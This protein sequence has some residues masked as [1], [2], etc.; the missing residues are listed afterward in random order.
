MTNSSTFPHIMHCPYNRFP[1]S[2]YFFYTMK[3]K[4]S[5]INPVQMDDIRLLEHW[6]VGD[7]KT[8][9]SD[10]NSEEILP[11]EEIIYP[12]DKSLPNESTFLLP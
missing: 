2:N 8:A 9:V 1:G 5:L 7:A 12:N 11:A 3:R 10:G 4:H 6:Q